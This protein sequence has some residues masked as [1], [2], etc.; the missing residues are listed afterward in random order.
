M[1]DG[2]YYTFQGNKT[3]TFLIAGFPGFPYP[4]G[5]VPGKTYYWRVD[6]VDSKANSPRKGEVL[7]FSIAPRAAY[8]PLPADGAKSVEPN[9]VLRWTEGLKARLHTVYF[10]DDLET[11][12]NAVGGKLQSTKTF[13][14]GDLVPGTTYYWRVDEFDG[15]ATYKGKVWS[16]TVDDTAESRQVK[17]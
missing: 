13:T 8:N 5:L 11:V 6:E 3:A 15:R 4:D 1:N 17:D 10:G 2:V 7:S 12:T 9:V 14:P 16:F